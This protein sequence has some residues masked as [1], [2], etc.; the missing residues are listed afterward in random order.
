[1]M[2]TANLLLSVGAEFLERLDGPLN[3]RL[4]IMPTVV[5]ILAIRAGL[6]DARNGQPSFLCGIV[7]HPAERPR[8]IRSALA[9]IGRIFI[10][11]VVLDTIYQFLVGETFRAGQVII[12]AV[13]C[14]IAPY[15]LLRGP[16]TLL[17]RA[18][19]KG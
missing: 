17:A 6:K 2:M 13:T 10:I 1:M 16:V 3:F 18:I 12:V 15:I 8:L 5:A 9:D 19:R 14:A 7:N 4:I 11:A